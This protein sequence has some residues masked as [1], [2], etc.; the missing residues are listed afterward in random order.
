M[1]IGEKS[2]EIETRI[3]PEWCPG[4]GN[5]GIFTAVKRALNELELPLHETVFVSGIGCHGKFP[6]FVNTYGFESI[7]GRALPVAQA[8]KLANH[9]LTVIVNA[10]DGDTYG[11]GMSHFIHA[12]RRNVNLTLIAHNNMIYGLTTG[13]VSPTSKQGHKTKST[14]S[15]VL[16]K[17]VNPLALALASDATFVSR[18][19]PAKMDHL[20]GL[21]KSAINHKGT[22]LVDV[23]QPC[24]TFN[25]VETYDFYNERVY[26]LEDEGHDPSDKEAAWK[27]A[28]EW[29]ERIP[30]GLFYKEERPTYEDGLPQLQTPLIKQDIMS[31]DISGLM[32][33]FV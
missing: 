2:G 5:Y 32:E 22:A 9:E 23:L 25:K 27:K 31:V 26:L 6:H 1:K 29:G 20:V 16:E 8:I 11:I 24:V 30:I 15:G 13:Q 18:G 28:N 19:Y 7:H 3:K 17:G 14:P 21:I 10:G 4:C 33:G 12:M